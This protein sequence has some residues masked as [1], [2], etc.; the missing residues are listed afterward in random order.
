MNSLRDHGCQMLEKMNNERSQP[1]FFYMRYAGEPCT[2]FMPRIFLGDVSVVGLRI[3]HHLRS[4]PIVQMNH[5]FITFTRNPSHQARKLEKTERGALLIG[6]KKKFNALL[7]VAVPR[8]NPS[9]D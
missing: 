4:A 9:V 3:Q 7:S 1:S 5:L 6:G 8:K 2:C